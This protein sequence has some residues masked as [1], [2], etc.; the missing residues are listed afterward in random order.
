MH[1]NIKKLEEKCIRRSDPTKDYTIQGKI[2]KVSNVKNYPNSEEFMVAA[3]RRKTDQKLV[4]IKI[5][6]EREFLSR[7]FE[8]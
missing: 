3:A 7:T 6:P 2:F 5:L 1:E 8:G 4:A